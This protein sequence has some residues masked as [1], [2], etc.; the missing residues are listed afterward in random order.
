MKEIQWHHTV[1]PTTGVCVECCHVMGAAASLEWLRS[2]KGTADRPS[3]P[4][5]IDKR[6]I[7][8]DEA[9]AGSGRE[10]LQRGREAGT[11]LFLNKQLLRSLFHF[12]AGSSGEILIVSLSDAFVSFLLLFVFFFVMQSLCKD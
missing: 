2:H 5:L 1:T 11:K 10:N 6:I 3:T 7:A 4:N 9:S 8:F 12:C